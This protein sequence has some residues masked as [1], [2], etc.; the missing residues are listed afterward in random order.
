MKEENSKI[1]SQEYGNVSMF[2][3][4]FDHM[5]LQVEQGGNPVPIVASSGQVHSGVDVG[6]KIMGLQKD[7][8]ETRRGSTYKCV[9]EGGESMMP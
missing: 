4:I 6:E 8:H 1:S 7:R 9:G 2:T 5:L 3:E